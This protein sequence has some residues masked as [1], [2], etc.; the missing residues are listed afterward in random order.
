M[1]M[2]LK[3]ERHDQVRATYAIEDHRERFIA[4]NSLAFSL[5]GQTYV[6]L[7]EYTASMLMRRR[8]DRLY[9][10]CEDMIELIDVG[11]PGRHAGTRISTTPSRS[12]KEGQKGRSYSRRTVEPALMWSELIGIISALAVDPTGSGIFAAGAY[13]GTV[14]LYDSLGELNTLF[15]SNTTSGITQVSPVFITISLIPC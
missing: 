12:S 3:R 4:P 2:G 5:D 14:G 7:V 11:T 1:D 13:T 10:G 8:R 15:Y 9:C 6:S